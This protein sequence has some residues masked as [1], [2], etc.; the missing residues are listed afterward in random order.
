M[1]TITINRNEKTAIPFAISDAANGLAAMRVTWSLAALD[2]MADRWAIRSPGTRVLRKVGNL[3]GS[4]A[5]ITIITQTAGSI[6]G[7]INLAVADFASLPDAQYAASLWVD[8]NANNDRCVTSGGF[9]LL[10]ITNDVSRMP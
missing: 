2:G 7:T 10:A 5:D 8:D 6:V 4:T 9:D 3:P 1:S